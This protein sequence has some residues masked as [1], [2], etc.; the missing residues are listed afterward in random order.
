VKIFLAPILRT[1]SRDAVQVPADFPWL[2]SSRHRK[3]LIALR[4]QISQ[5]R[6]RNPEMPGNAGLVHCYSDLGNIH[7]TVLPCGKLLFF[8]AELFGTGAWI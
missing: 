4:T 3:L 1:R 8:R 2:S 7:P 5:G 6:E